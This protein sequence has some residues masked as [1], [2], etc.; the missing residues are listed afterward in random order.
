[1]EFGRDP[2]VYYDPGVPGLQD[3]Q[4]KRWIEYGENEFCP[5]VPGDFVDGRYRII[6]LLG[7]GGDGMVWLAVDEPY[8]TYVPFGNGG[9]VS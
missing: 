2:T 9:L 5:I 3:P 1:M 8:P 7:F 4:S 6:S